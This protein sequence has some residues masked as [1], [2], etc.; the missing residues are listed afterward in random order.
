MKKTRYLSFLVS[1]LLASALI[2]SGCSNDD[3]DKSTTPGSNPG[4]EQEDEANNAVFATVDDA[5]FTVLRS[6]TDLTQY[7][8]NKVA[9]DEDGTVSGVEVLPSGWNTMT[10]TCDEGFVLD[11]TKPT[12]YS[13]AA[14]SITDALDYFSG[15]I[16]E[17]ITE[18]SLTADKYSWSYS[19]LGKLTFTKISGEEDLYATIDV[20]LSVMPELTQLRFI[21]ADS[22]EL[23]AT[24]KFTGTPYY[25]AGDVIRRNKDNTCWICVRPAG[26]PMFKDKSY[27]LCLNSVTDSAKNIINETTKTVSVY[28]YAGQK[29]DGKSKYIKSEHN[30]TYAKNLMSL[31]TAKAAF[32]TFSSLVNDAAWEKAA[33]DNASGFGNARHVY[34]ALQENGI[35]LM[36]LHML[37][38]GKD[39]PG[40]D[41]KNRDDYKNVMFAFAY[42]SP[43]DDSSR[44]LSLNNLPKDGTVDTTVFKKAAQLKTTQPFF[45]GYCNKNSVTEY[46]F[47]RIKVPAIAY[48]KYVNKEFLL[49]LTD[50]YDEVYLTSIGASPTQVLGLLEEDGYMTKQDWETK[51][52]DYASKFYYD[53]AYYLHGYPVS[54]KTLN[55]YEFSRSTWQEPANS[56]YRYKDNKANYHVI[57]SPELMIKDNKEKN[58]QP[59][60]PYSSSYTSVYVQREDTELSDGNTYFDYWSTKNSFIRYIDDALASWQEENE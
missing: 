53:F 26:G 34:E 44:G 21:S 31:K 37:S 52:A 41:T 20:N 36:A 28:H 29:N 42:G 14:A 33:T 58:G 49:S 30:W 4:S 15:L 48:S 22:K 45:Y 50:S 10:F 8:E 43:K 23:T 59:Q 24:N 5:A 6:L 38:D 54:D 35:D 40:S 19:G 57:V 25:H 1:L 17:S 16:G 32:H 51:A 55:F 7:D 9:D 46:L 12:V 2:F 39:G 11:S 13:I 18:S 47:T 3:D 60:K 56:R 27:W